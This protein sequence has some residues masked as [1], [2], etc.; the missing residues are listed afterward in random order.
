VNSHPKSLCNPK[1]HIRHATITPHNHSK[2]KVVSERYHHTSNAQVPTT[3][4][5]IL[6]ASNPCDRLTCWVAIKNELRACD[7]FRRMKY[8]EK[9]SKRGSVDIFLK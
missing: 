5:R 1:N 2:V 8:R 3:T 7:I 9:N 4:V 6:I